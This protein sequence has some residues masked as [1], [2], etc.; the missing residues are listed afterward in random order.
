MTLPQHINIRV[1][2]C[3][4]CPLAETEE[5]LHAATIGVWPVKCKHMNADIGNISSCAKGIHPQCTFPKITDVQDA[6]AD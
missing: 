1:S 2:N 4:E 5:Q 3:L 6:L